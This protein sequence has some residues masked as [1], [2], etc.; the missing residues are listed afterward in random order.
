MWGQQF[1]KAPDRGSHSFLLSDRSMRSSF[2][3]HGPESDAPYTNYTSHTDIDTGTGTSTRS[4]QVGQSDL[5]YVS[6]FTYD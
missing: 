2:Q 6:D 5:K 3:I 1:H 4:P